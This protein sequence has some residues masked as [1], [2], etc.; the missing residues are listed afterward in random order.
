MRALLKLISTA[1]LIT[2]L[3]FIFIIFFVK[4]PEAQVPTASNIYD[5]NG[6][7]I[8]RL[9]IEN[10]VPVPINQ[11]PIHLQNA[12]IA[13]EDSRFY[14]HFGIDPIAILRAFYINLQKG[15]IVEGGS[16]ITQQL[17]KNLY[18]SHERTFKR[19]L[20]EALLTLKLEL[21]YDKKKI[22][23]MYLNNIYFGH[24]AYGV[25]AASEKYFGKPVRDLNIAESALLAGLPKSPEYYSPLKNFQAS[26]ER[27]ELVINLMVKMGYISEEQGEEAKNTPIHLTGTTSNKKKA[28]YFVQFVINEIAKIQPEIAKNLYKGGYNVYTTLD[29]VLQNYAEESISNILTRKLPDING[30][31]QPQAALVAINPHNGYILSMVGGRDYNNTQYNRALARRQPGSAFKPFLYLTLLEKGFKTI[32]KMMCEP[33]E[34]PMEQGKKYR[35]TDYDGGYHYRPISLREALVISDNVVS[36]RWMNLVGPGSVIASARKMGIK[37]PLAP[38]LSLALGSSE[39]TPLEICAAYAPF[40]NGGFRV[41]PLAILRLED[42]KGNIIINNSPVKEKVLDEKIGYLIT[43]I[44]K[45]VFKSGGTGSHLDI[46]Y[47]AAGKTGTSQGNRDAWFVGYTPDLVAS[48]YVGN[49]NPEYPL[50]STGGWIAGPIW[51]DFIN[52]SSERLNSKDF[53]I[54]EGVIYREICSKTALIP[55]DTCPTKTEI[56]IKG[57]EP[58]KKC[59]TNHLISEDKDNEGENDLGENLNPFPSEKREEEGSK[60]GLPFFEELE[61]LIDGVEKL[62]EPGEQD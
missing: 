23:E 41:K 9:Y 49:D 43:D 35:P 31:N 42:V 1:L 26:K 30:V 46:K 44:L 37:S 18:L 14:K 10:R 28:P 27:Q 3:F 38:N 48:V 57:T 16:T 33:V 59:N 20:Y 4:F 53:N 32:D 21:I 15:R 29:L 8:E 12:F 58:Q 11:I 50:W 34:F 13:V 19:K 51:A 52:K 2:I 6:K 17:V 22:L 7:L 56:F 36:V 61:E 45:D 60:N 47:P 39:V 62:I 25:E 5:V 24:G 55:N 40:A 54:P